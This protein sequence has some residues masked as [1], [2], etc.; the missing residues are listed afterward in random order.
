MLDRIVEDVR[1]RL[2]ALLGR[3]SHVRAAA[4]AADPPRDFAGALAAPGL[5]VI[6]EIKRASP[7]RGLID[8]DLD[9]AGQAR[10]YML[11]GASAVSVLTEP[12]H[13]R[14]SP[15]D[16]VD[17]RS[18]V[19]IPVLRKDFTLH[20]LHIWEARAMGADAVLLIVAV[21][22][23]P[24]LEQLVVE[25][26]RAGLAALVEVH[27]EAEAVRAMS[28]GASIVGVNN[29]DL[30]TFEVDLGTAERLAAVIEGKALTVAE[31]GIQGPGDAQ[32]AI[33]AGYDAVLVG[34]YLVRSADPA[35]AI[36]DL[37]AGDR[38]EHSS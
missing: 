3:E 17:A 28:A 30:T 8:A 32:R 38:A 12:D 14:G 27:D 37:R 20:P 22:D 7:S 35:G 25:A 26:G 10:R 16:L 4:E 9:P 34:E 33:D 11:G 21:L 15:D 24:T 18:A 1:A 29:R 5:S 13:F 23:D 31:S 19:D 2:P 6:A 36:R